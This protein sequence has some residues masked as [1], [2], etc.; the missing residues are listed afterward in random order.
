ML[1]ASFRESW[2]PQPSSSQ[3]PSLQ[4]HTKEQVS[5]GERSRVDV[6]ARVTLPTQHP[7]G[8]PGVSVTVTAVC[9]VIFTGD[10]GA[11]LQEQKLWIQPFKVMS[12][13]FHEM[14][15]LL[16]VWAGAQAYLMAILPRA[17]LWTFCIPVFLSRTQRI[18]QGSTGCKEL[19]L[20][21]TPSV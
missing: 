7:K 3:C 15:F 6:P 20:W 14:Q 13:V 1:S 5:T 12:L 4:G 21:D 2:P 19:P 11:V 9:E 16:Q 10:T 17:S 18:L 8:A